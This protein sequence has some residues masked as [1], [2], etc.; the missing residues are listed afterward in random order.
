MGQVVQQGSI[1][2]TALIVP[3]VYVQIV[4][5]GVAALNGVPTNILGVV[6]TASWGPVNSPTVVGTMADFAASFGPVLVRPHDLG[7]A[8]AT[9]VQQGA[10]NFR[11]VRVTDGTD[12]TAT[13][14][15]GGNNYGGA[16]DI[17]FA[18]KYSGSL[19]NGDTVQLLPSAAASTW[20][21]VVTRTGMA[22]E[23]FDNILFGTPQQ[24]WA[25]VA[26]A[27]NHGSG[28]L[29]GPSQLIRA[30]ANPAGG[31][32]APSSQQ[33]VLAGGSDGVAN[34][35]SAVLMGNDASG[36]RTGMYALRGSGASVAFIAEL[37]DTTTFTTQAGFGLTEGIYMV[38][39][40]PAGDTING[41]GG[42]GAV[43]V[44]AN[45]GIDSYAFKY[46]FGDW[47]YWND[48][49][50]GVLRL[51]SPQ[52][53]VAGRLAA[54][55]PEQSALNKPLYGVVA[56]QTSAA[57]QVY[58]AAELQT[59]IGA[60]I[61]L[62][63]NPSPGGNYFSCR[64][65]HNSSSDPLRN[66]DSYTRLTNYIAFTLNTGMGLYVG[67]LQSASERSNA[68]AT[69]E[70]FLQGMQDQGMI[71]DANATDPDSPAYRVTLDAGNNPAERVALGYQQAD[72]S[73][74]YLAVVEKFLINLEGS[75]AT[76]LPAAAAA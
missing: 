27:I 14:Q 49:V 17:V 64:A 71:G 21:V 33:V 72:V 8:V 30:T 9:A 75:T 62:I 23:V 2:T 4:A 69:L 11:C 74:K 15:F 39:V 16:G 20:K 3:D 25:Q 43:A 38:G 54:L 48:T 10:N 60:G 7:T 58:S 73:V 13:A 24:F 76:V 57:N 32:D 61:D 46:L 52:G 68:R 42:V 40:T 55:S 19:A 29:R 41:S 44:K 50:N 22:P 6:G 70:H 67:Q 65:G 37:A 53:F 34:V 66:G 47:V 63:T 45:A 36:A 28:P 59:L 35:T 12:S 5:P 31:A 1:N 51:V 26:S 18:S 56:T